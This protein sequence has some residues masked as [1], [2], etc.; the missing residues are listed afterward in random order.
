VFSDAYGA[1]VGGVALLA[2][3]RAAGAPAA[4]VPW[5]AVGADGAPPTT[6]TDVRASLPAS[7]L[8]QYATLQTLAALDVPID[9]AM[10]LFRRGLRLIARGR[11]EQSTGPGAVTPGPEI[12][13]EI[14]S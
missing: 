1:T 14:S 7:M 11:W 10:R 5:S 12:P 2:P 6:T 8:L 9:E 3:K 4:T 13:E